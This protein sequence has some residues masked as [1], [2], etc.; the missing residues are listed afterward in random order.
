MS[1]FKNNFVVGLSAGLAAAIIAPILI[2]AVKKGSRPMAKSL[3]KGG[4]LLYQKG[5]EAVASSGETIEDLLAEVHA[6]ETDKLAGTKFDTGTKAADNSPAGN[7][8]SHA[9]AV[10]TDAMPSSKDGNLS[11]T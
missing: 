8:G 5:R 1:L 10:K 6:E 3:V 9:A 2:P 4:M 7:G 11:A